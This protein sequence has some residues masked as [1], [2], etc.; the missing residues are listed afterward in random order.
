[1]KCVIYLDRQ[2]SGKPGKRARDTGASADLNKDGKIDVHEQEALLTPRYLLACELALRQAGH[3]VISISDGSYGDRHRR[4]NAYAG[5]FP[6]SVPQ[7]YIAAHFNA[8]W[9]GRDGSGYGA[10]F[11]DHRSR[12]GPELASRIAR[13]LRMVAPELNG[14]KCIPSKPDDWTRN[15]WAT[16][17]VQQP[18]AL[19]LEPAFIDCPDHA[20]LFSKEGLNTIGKAIARGVD[21]WA[22][23]NEV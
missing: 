20:E 21:A 15:A 17:Q 7:I 1:M 2:H 14:V 16:I 22:N 12:S 3:T 9:G 6:R 11:Y 5:S 8:G 19:C 23:L 13:Q 18:I 10:I 4:V